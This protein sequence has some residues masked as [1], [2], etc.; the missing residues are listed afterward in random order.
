M[1]F[2]RHPN[3]SSPL[4]MLLRVENFKPAKPGSQPATRLTHN[5]SLQGK[6]SQKEFVETITSKLVLPSVTKAASSP[7]FATETP[8]AF[9]A[10]QGK[11]EYSASY[12]VLT[13]I[14]RLFQTYTAADFD[15]SP[16]IRA[17]DNVSDELLRLKKRVQSKI[18]D[19]EDQ[20]SASESSRRRKMKEFAEAFDVS[21][22]DV[23]RAFEL[24]DSRL[25]EV[26]NTAIRIALLD[27]QGEQL[28]T[29]D[30]QKTRAAEAKDLIQYFLEFNKGI[31]TRLDALRKS[32]PEGEYKAAIIARRIN[33]I[34]KE[35]DISGT[36][37]ARVNIEKYCEG[38]EK[39]LLA[40][41]DQAYA[42]ADRD[43]M[44]QIARTLLDFNGGNSCIQTYVNQH[45]FFI[46]LLKIAET[47]QEAANR[48]Q[49]FSKV[50]PSLTRLYDEISAAIFNEW[51]AI[52]VIFP[53]AAQVMQVFVQR[54]FAQSTLT[55]KLWYDNQIQNFIEGLMQRAEEHS[56]LA[57]VQVLAQTH[58]S[59]ARLVANI[60]RFDETV[61]AAAL[62]SLALTSMVN[63]CFDDLF[64]PYLENDRY[65]KLETAW[66]LD[67]LCEI[68]PQQTQNNSKTKS[69]G[70]G[71][72]GSRSNA[73]SP[74][75]DA[76]ANG[77][78]S[79]AVVSSFMSSVVTTMSTV[80]AMGAELSQQITGQQQAN[81]AGVL[82]EVSMMPTIEDAV[83]CFNAHS[84]SLRRC[85][86]LCQSIDLPSCA[87]SLFKLLVEHVGI[88]SIHAALDLQLEDLGFIDSKAEPEFGHLTI[89]KV[90]MRILQIFQFQFQVQLLPLL[91]GSKALH[92]EMVAFKNEFFAA[93]EQKANSILKKKI[94]GIVGWMELTLSRQKKTDYK[95]RDDVVAVNTLS[96][97]STAQPC[98]QIVETLRH[99]ADEAM[100]SLEGDNV[101]AYLT[102]LG[103]ALHSL[104]IDHFKK[105]PVS[106]AGGLVLTKDLAKYHD[107]VLS[108]GKIE[109]LEE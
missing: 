91:A 100:A 26:G 108:F 46:N 85:K 66:L 105:F 54:I 29:I 15:A 93:T 84:Q 60:H 9:P 94:A 53:N 57:F 98:N 64:V 42:Q 19:Q 99:A 18:E 8:G 70:R 4:K 81:S 16:F 13:N 41:F 14:S 40:E 52:V 67:T 47:D 5:E 78:S 32:G 7:G 27:R 50:D 59:T 12:A 31:F 72:T 96:T 69:S 88:K 22:L 51:D 71:K 92:R 104:L 28:E 83:K 109:L 101:E 55:N 21:A 17:F 43:T 95:P 1:Y 45:A 62:G 10:L 37:A 63:R 89:I 20:A 103:I 11:S 76:A 3:A 86:E 58:S 24:L 74:V 97:Q 61:I 48:E 36:E 80:S 107:T 102:E 90:A 38:L 73:S 79:S 49:D 68:L 2:E 6:F 33:T 25:S 39:S 35:V 87:S 77:I 82:Q 30:K 23:H 65:V 44:N 75:K 56:N 34:A 106:Y